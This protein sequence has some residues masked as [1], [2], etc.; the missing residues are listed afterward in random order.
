MKNLNRMSNNVS[1]LCYKLLDSATPELKKAWFKGDDDGLHLFCKDTGRHIET[2]SP[3][4]AA[5]LIEGLTDAEFNELSRILEKK[6][7]HKAFGLIAAPVAQKSK[8][9]FDGWVKTVAPK[10]MKKF[11][12]KPFKAIGGIFSKRST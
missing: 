12:A 2:I 11:A 4:M 10:I 9:W 1:I 6:V 5:L 8:G 3:I 7:V